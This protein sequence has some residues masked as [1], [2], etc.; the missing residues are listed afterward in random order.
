MPK[1]TDIPA[2]P[3]SPAVRSSGRVTRE[4][5]ISLI[6][7]LFGGGVEAG[8]PDETMPIRATSIRGQLQFWWR[9]TRGA[10]FADHR[11]LFIRHGKIWGTTEKASPVEIAVSD[12][13]VKPARS[14]ARYDWNKKAR[15]GKG[16]WRLVW[17]APF[18]DSPLPYALFS[19]QGKQPASRNGD[20]EEPP[21]SFIETASFTLR[22][23]YPEKLGEDVETAVW[24]WVNFGGLG[25]RTRR[26]CGALLCKELAPKN[27][28]D[29]E[30]WFRSGVFK[31]G[32]TVREW[33]TMREV[34]LV[35]KQEQAP[36]D[37]WKQVIGCLQKF[38]QG[39]EIGRNRGSGNRPGRSRWPEPETI[40]RVT[41][42][43]SSQHARLAYIPDDAFPRAEFGLPIVF[44]FQ[45]QGEPPDT[46]LYPSNAPDGA[47]RERMA[48]PLILKPLALANGQ[49][50][51]IILRLVTPDV[52]EVQL[53]PANASAAKALNVATDTDLLAGKRL[54][55]KLRDPALATYR[56][57]PLEDSP[58]G[59]AIEA[60]LLFVRNTRNKDFEEITR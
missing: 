40:R 11:K 10:Q 26:G 14:C 60:F 45:G 32:G 56:D 50:V 21:A 13:R 31:D 24:A 39:E 4:Y 57:S 8:A 18:A 59:S 58:D 23:W 29:L 28:G 55:P 42:K 20:P 43:R 12:V 1:V 47:A 25:T 6:T 52:T 7:P 2:C 30:R 9:A 22:L 46:V 51:P 36:I 3:V 49:A 54:V 48:S 41:A 33:P 53:K 19:F 27:V 16:G 34:L 44:H 5:Q 35:G 15:G 17:E 37:A 38:R